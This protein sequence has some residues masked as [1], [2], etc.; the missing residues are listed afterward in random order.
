MIFPYETMFFRALEG[1][2]VTIDLTPQPLGTYNTVPAYNGTAQIPQQPV[3][4]DCMS[5]KK[6]DEY[7]AKKEID[8]NTEDRKLKLRERRKEEEEERRICR[9]ELVY[10]DKD[11]T[12]KA[13]VENTRI[14]PT[15]IRV[16]NMEWPVLRKYIRIKN[17]D[18]LIYQLT[19]FVDGEEKEVY[20]DRKKTG[21]PSYLPERLLTR[22][23]VFTGRKSQKEEYVTQ[24][25]A[26]LKNRADRVRGVFMSENK[27]WSILDNEEV[28]YNN[29][30]LT[31]EVLLKKSRN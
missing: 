8:L 26:I 12:F 25:F 3:I 28:V 15:P 9:R 23:I 10:P 20:L 1:H 2:D 27:G 31:W 7:K 17:P 21:K 19:A 18:D 14:S 11:G 5:A 24:L 29:G 16:T 22:G 4:S 6:L 30:E 13:T